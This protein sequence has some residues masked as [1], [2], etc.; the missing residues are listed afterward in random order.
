MQL[1][2]LWLEDFRSYD[3]LD[4][5]LDPGVTVL[6]GP[7]GSGK[8]NLAEAIAWLAT[9]GSFRG[10]SNEA[11]VR[12]GADRAIVRGEVLQGERRLLVEAEIPTRGRTRVLVNRQRLTK[13]ADVVGTLRVTV[14]APDDLR[15]VKGGPSERRR[16]LDD[17]LVAV[18]ARAP[19]ALRDLDRVLRQRNALLSGLPGDA[20]RRGCPD[21]AATATLDV[22]DARLATSGEQVATLR[23]ELVGRL[24][25][26]VAAAY[27]TL[28][29]RPTPIGLDYRTS[30]SGSLEHALAAARDTDVRR[31]LTSVGPHRD[32]LELLVDGLPAR[33][34]ASQGEQRTLALALRLGVH[35]V[36]TAVTGTMPVIVL[37]DVFSELDPE[38][39][40]ALV[41]AVPEAQTVITTAGPLPAAVQPGR[42][43]RI[44]ELT[45][46]RSA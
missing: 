29:G 28:A 43:L 26:P 42:V 22:W 14:F 37:D 46:G 12:V 24:T 15:L 18:S 9:L 20:R 8:T 23:R 7:N 25:E 44:E 13:A 41:G 6:V 45:D 40:A 2:H 30:W 27:A 3:R 32:E 11:L 36:I 31:G 39:S 34:H 35:Q 4:L 38:R 21:A 5:D 10:V 17:A 33:T 16:L 1:T 19:G